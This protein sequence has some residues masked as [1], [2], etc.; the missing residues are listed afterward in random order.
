MT[1][2]AYCFGPSLE[3]GSNATATVNAAMSS[4]FA[5]F[6]AS[7]SFS[8][9]CEAGD[10]IQATLADFALTVDGLTVGDASGGA[11]YIMLATSS[12]TLRTSFVDLRVIA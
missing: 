2:R 7:G 10:S 1:W 3:A 11:D 4:D 5:A 8:L 12:T 9:P 6:T